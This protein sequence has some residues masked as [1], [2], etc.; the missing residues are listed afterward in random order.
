[1]GKLILDKSMSLDGFIAGEYDS[2]EKPLGNE[3]AVLHEWLFKGEVPSKHNDFFKM[4]EKSRQVFD[5]LFETTGALIVGRRTYD[6]VGGWG[7][8]HPIHG[9]PLFVVTHHVPDDVPR[10]STPFTFVTDGIQRAY[11]QAIAAAGNKNVGIAGASVA[12]QCLA[13]GLLDEIHIHLVPALMGKGIRLFEETDITSKLECME[14]V[15]A[16]S[17]THLKYRVLNSLV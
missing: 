7:G 1:M 5:E 13:A 8:S 14:V 16:S 17:V 6:L 12:R 9:I 4:S 2:P 15:V 3:G 11:E 10:G